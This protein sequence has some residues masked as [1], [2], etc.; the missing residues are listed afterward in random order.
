MNKYSKITV[1]A[2]G[3]AGTGAAV[4]LAKKRAAGE[5]IPPAVAEYRNTELGR[6]AT[7]SKGIRYTNGNYEAFAR[8]K[9]PEGVEN[10]HAYIVG[11]GLAALAA[12]GAWVYTG[13]NFYA[14]PQ[15]LHSLWADGVPH[16][17]ASFL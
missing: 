1:A 4:A 6:H 11:S 13:G 2:L 5:K 15:R 7:N 17:G 10:K 9:K 8:P 16:A 3:A 12:A 14:L